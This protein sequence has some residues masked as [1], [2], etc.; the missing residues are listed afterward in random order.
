MLFKIKNDC[1]NAN[2]ARTIRFTEKIFDELLK[3]SEKSNVSFNFLVLQ[4]YNY[5]LENLEDK[6]KQ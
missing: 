3:I 1:R 6:Q 4:C 5:A 2:I